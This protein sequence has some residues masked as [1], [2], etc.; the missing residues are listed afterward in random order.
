MPPSDLLPFTGGRI[1]HFRSADN[2]ASQ[3][4]VS[5][6][7]Q[8]MPLEPLLVTTKFTSVNFCPHFTDPNKLEDPKDGEFRATGGL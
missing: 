7:R 2:S 4:T 8:N 6:C 5:M 1:W 3:V